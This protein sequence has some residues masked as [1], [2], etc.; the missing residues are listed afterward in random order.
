MNSYKTHHHHAPRTSSIANERSAPTTLDKKKYNAPKYRC[1]YRKR[2]Q[3]VHVLGEGGKTAC[4]R[5]YTGTERGAS[6]QWKRTRRADEPGNKHSESMNWKRTQRADVLETNAARRFTNTA[7]RCTGEKTQRAGVLISL[8]FEI[9][10]NF[11]HRFEAG[12]RLTLL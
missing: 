2:T 3:R 5:R 9:H 12:P 4:T 8:G 1:K 10:V 7:C 6:T 11:N